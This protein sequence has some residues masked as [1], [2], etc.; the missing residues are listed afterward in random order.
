MNEQICHK[1]K[2]SSTDSSEERW[3]LLKTGAHRFRV[4]QRERLRQAF[5]E[6]DAPLEVLLEDRVQIPQRANQHVLEILG[7]EKV[8]DAPAAGADDA[9]RSVKYIES[10]NEWGT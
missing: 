1:L 8:V 6:F 2:S 9:G 10:P 5:Q 4:K 7:A 3:R